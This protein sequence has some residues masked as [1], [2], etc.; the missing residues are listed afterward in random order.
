MTISW[1]RRAALTAGFGAVAAVATA[2]CGHAAEKGRSAASSTDVAGT[3]D[4][5]MLIRHAEKPT[6]DGAPFGITED[7]QQDPESLIVRGWNRAG[8]LV[9]LFAPAVGAVRSGLLKPGAVYASN[10]GSKGSKRPLQTVTPTAARLGVTVNTKYTKG[11]EAALASELNGLHGVTLVGWEHEAIPDIV[12]HLPNVTPAVPTSW[13]GDRFDVVWVFTR[14]GNGWQFS[15]VPQELLAG[16]LT[17][18][19]G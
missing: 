14:K 1:N 16:D 11:Q 15:Q 13:P 18:P 10:P 9:E 8:A 19:I 5:L 3:G 6:G 12:S 4:V 7:G 17:T 2:G